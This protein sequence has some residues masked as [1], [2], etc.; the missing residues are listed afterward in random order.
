MKSLADVPLSVLDPTKTAEALT[1]ILGGS[2]L[3]VEAQ[4]DGPVPGVLVRG[5][6]DQLRDDPI[7]T[8]R[9]PCPATRISCA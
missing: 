1:K 3:Y 9:R 8:G 4:I 5:T 6:P 2:G 7:R